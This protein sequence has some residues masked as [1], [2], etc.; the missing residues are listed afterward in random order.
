MSETQNQITNALVEDTSIKTD[1]QIV[2]N[3]YQ[4][5]S[6]KT[7]TRLLSIL[8]AQVNQKMFR[9]YKK[10]KFSN[11]R[12]G[13]LC[14]HERVYNNIHSNIILKLPPDYDVTKVL[15]LMQKFWLK[16]N[17]KFKLYFDFQVRDQFKCTDYAI[18]EYDIY[19]DE[20]FVVI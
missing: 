2:A 19:K 13:F 11:R 3:T 14:N 5:V 6:F 7:L 15:F 4:N 1:I 18:K 16:L 9:Y 12:I 10:K 17:P 20:K 8:N